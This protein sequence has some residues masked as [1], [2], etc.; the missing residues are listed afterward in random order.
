MR[1]SLKDRYGASRARHALLDGGP[2]PGQNTFVRSKL[3]AHLQTLAETGTAALEKRSTGSALRS[4]RTFT[5]CTGSRTVGSPPRS[6]RRWRT[7]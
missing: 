5:F 2:Q 4:R 6:P 3:R 1:K 7:A